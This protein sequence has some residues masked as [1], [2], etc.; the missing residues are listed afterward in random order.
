MKVHLLEINGSPGAADKWLN[1]VVDGIMQLCIDPYFPPQ[2]ELISAKAKSAASTLPS[3]PRGDSNGSP[4]KASSPQN[5]A[6]SG[7]ASICEEGMP[8]NWSLLYKASQS[9]VLSPKTPLQGITTS[10]SELTVNCA[11]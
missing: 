3:T 2:P 9:Q 8:R 6:I 1:D 11:A 4:T 5:D 7:A 10:L